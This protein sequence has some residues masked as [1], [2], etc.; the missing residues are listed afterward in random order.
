[1]GIFDKEFK[2][3]GMMNSNVLKIGMP[4]LAND[5]GEDRQF[6]LVSMID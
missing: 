1:M 2:Y 4:S 3:I 6:D 5:Y